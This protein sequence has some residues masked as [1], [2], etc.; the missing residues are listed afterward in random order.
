MYT[1]KL[2][3]YQK[4]VRENLETV[5]GKELMKQRIIQSEGN[6]GQ[7][8]QDYEYDRLWRRGEIGVKLEIL[9]VSMGHNLRRYH[10][11]KQKPKVNIQ[12]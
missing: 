7:I 2:D 4:E 12:A 11:R 1:R 9:L 5:E 10:N 3:M 8:K 6:F